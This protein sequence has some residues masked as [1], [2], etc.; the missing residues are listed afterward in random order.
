MRN[1]LFD[2][3][4]WKNGKRVPFNELD[5]AYLSAHC[6]QYETQRRQLN[7]MKKLKGLEEEIVNP[8]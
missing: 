8:N 3:E 7:L 6:G 1:T 4:S 2:P 5:L